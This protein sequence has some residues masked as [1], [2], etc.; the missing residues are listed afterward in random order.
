MYLNAR[1]ISKSHW[2]MSYNPIGFNYLANY[3]CGICFYL[4]ISHLSPASNDLPA[5]PSRIATSYLQF[6]TDL[7]KCLPCLLNGIVPA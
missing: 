7:R 3:R 2:V 6:Q 5:L 4:Y 1:L